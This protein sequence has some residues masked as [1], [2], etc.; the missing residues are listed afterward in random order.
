MKYKDGER[1]QHNLRQ[2]RLWKEKAPAMQTGVKARI[3][4]FGLV[5]Q[6]T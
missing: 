6:M 5:V 3:H 1:L 4:A 2:Q